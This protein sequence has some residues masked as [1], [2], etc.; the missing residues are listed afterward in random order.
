LNEFIFSARLDNLS[1]SYCALTALLLSDSPQSIADDSRIR[2]IA[3][4]D[5]EE[6]GSESMQGAASN[7]MEQI[8]IRITTS[9]RSKSDSEQNLNEIMFRKSFLISADMAHGVHPNY[10]EK[11]QSDHRPAI[12]GGLVIKNN[13]NQR[14]A[15]NSVTSF[16][17]HELAKRNGIP[18]QEFVV[19]NDSPCGSTIGPILASR[20]G[21]RTVDLGAP[22]LAMHSIRETCG[23]TDIDH[24]VKL[25]KSF[26]EQFGNIDATTNFE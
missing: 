5:N 15:T 10:S 16:Y 7:M 18:L 13:A 6:V 25:F 19:R 14:Y 11:H 8:L 23:T 2:L 17:I 9:T 24:T 3:L 20:C 4:F 12:N 22:Q 21:M 1:S 26:F